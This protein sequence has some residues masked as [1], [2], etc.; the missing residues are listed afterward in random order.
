[1]RESSVRERIKYHRENEV[2]IEEFLFD[3]GAIQPID[4]D[5]EL[6]FT[7]KFASRLEKQIPQVR[8]R[9]VQRS[10]LTRLFGVEKE[11]IELVDR[12]Y[13]AYKIIRT[14]HRWPG[15]AALILDTAADL[16]F[17]ETTDRWENV[18]PKQRFDIVQSLRS[19]HERC[20]ACD[21]SLQMTP[22]PVTSACSD[23]S[24]VAFRCSECNE[25]FMEFHPSE[26]GFDIEEPGHNWIP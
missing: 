3:V 14:I 25:H 22:E 17:R 21:G 9:G 12:S 16:A 7:E 19:F 11:D 5:E 23:R 24:V 4:G 10:D 6:Q 8:N 18:P 20:P 15:D 13:P 1:M 2:D 26:Y